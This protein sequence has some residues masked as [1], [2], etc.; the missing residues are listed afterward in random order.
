MSAILG[1][2]LHNYNNVDN[3]ETAQTV[4]STYMSYQNHGAVSTTGQTYSQFYHS[5]YAPENVSNQQPNYISTNYSSSG[6]YVEQNQN[7]R[8]QKHEKKTPKPPYSY[9]S[10]IC[11]A[12]AETAEKKATLREIIRF[13][14][15]HF[16]YYQSNK[17]WHGSIRHNLTINDCFVKLPRQPGN[18]CC[19][20]TIDPAFQDMF[21]NGSL[22]RRRYRYKE[23]TSNWNRTKLNNLSRR[24]SHKL[25]SASNERVSFPAHVP[26][27][28][29]PAAPTDVSPTTVPTLY[30]STSSATL[31]R[32]TSS[33]GCY[34][35]DLQT[36]T[37]ISLPSP[38]SSSSSWSQADELDDILNSLDMYGSMDAHQQLSYTNL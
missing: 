30:R 7:I 28:F 1:H 34:S 25:R 4:P 19:F 32:S 12:I 14:E 9:I 29:S 16:T 15:S 24:M 2:Y 8:S 26:D 17:K 23:G 3:Y 35:P 20:W 31:Y 10:L 36:D 21:D 11:M 33:D 27:H 37:N 18:K 22:R 6:N 5:C 13:I 38:S